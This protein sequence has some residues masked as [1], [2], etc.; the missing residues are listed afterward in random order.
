MVPLPIKTHHGHVLVRPS[1]LKTVPQP[2]ELKVGEDT[3]F[4]RRVIGAGYRAVHTEE[5]LTAYSHGSS[6][7]DE[8]GKRLR[9]PIR[10]GAQPARRAAPRPRTSKGGMARFAERET[11]KQ[12]AGKAKGSGSWLNFMG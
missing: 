8:P 12:P 11:A 4:V 2:E 10:R 5:E 6:V 9:P 1:V 7:S 3:T